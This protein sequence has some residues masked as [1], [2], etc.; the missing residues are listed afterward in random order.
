MKKSL[1]VNFLVLILFIVLTLLM[2]YPTVLKMGSGVRD[3]GDPFHLTWVMAWNVKAISHLDFQDYF[4]TNIFFPYKR[5]LAYSEF[6]FPQSIV[7]LPVL[8][9][10]GNP[11]FAYNFIF[12]LSFLTSGF[13]AYLLA[14]YLTSSTSGGILAGVIYSFSPFMFLHFRPCADTCS[15]RNSPCAIVSPQVFYK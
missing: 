11:I 5:T 7:A 2:T 4:N 6:L 15:W 3:L 8:L 10:S 12:L 9:L 1:K 14:R 13:G